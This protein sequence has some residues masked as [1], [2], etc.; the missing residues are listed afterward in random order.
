MDYSRYADDLTFSTN[1]RLFLISESL[2]YDELTKEIESAG[3]KLNEQKSRL[4]FKDSRQTVTG[5]VVNEKLM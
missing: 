1:D 5:L 2:F 4:Q 3:F